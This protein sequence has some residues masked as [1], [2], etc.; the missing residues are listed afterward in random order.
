MSDLQKDLQ[1]VGR[2]SAVPTILRVVSEITGLRFT[3]VARVTDAT[4]HACAVQ[5]RLGFG[6][7]P[8]TRSRSRPPS[9]ARCATPAAPS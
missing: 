6:M 7:E 5:D 1:A 8:A 2:I 3:A 9:A 4:W